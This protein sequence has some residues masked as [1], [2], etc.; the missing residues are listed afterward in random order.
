MASRTT[1]RLFLGPYAYIETEVELEAPPG[2][3]WAVFADFAAWP[4][5]SSGFMAFSEPPRRA[6]ARCGLVVKLRH[7]AL[8]STTHRPMVEVMR[9]GRELLWQ[10]FSWLLAPFWSGCHW[11]RFAPAP[12]GR[13]RL[14]H[15]T[16]Q[17]GLAV[18]FLWRGALRATEAGYH[19]WNEELAAEVAR[20][21][22]GAK[23]RAADAMASEPA[24]APL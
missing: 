6:G 14:R 3:A 7:G 23:R 10:D 4:R 5:W 12:G 15:G 20:R 24:A 21:A 22:A 9:A 1:T 2:E 19:E 17:V 18:P 13:T 16:R 11:F 8:K